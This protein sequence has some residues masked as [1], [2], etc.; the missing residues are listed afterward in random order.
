MYDLTHRNHRDVLLQNIDV[1]SAKIAGW[2]IGIYYRYSVCQSQNI[3][4]QN[5]AK[6]CLVKDIALIPH[7][8]TLTN[9]SVR[10]HN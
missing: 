8:H 2:A 1:W 6:L 10:S 5:I 7:P 4:R 9:F 3:D